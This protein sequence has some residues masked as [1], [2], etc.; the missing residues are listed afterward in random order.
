MTTNTP[1][2]ALAKA[3]APGDAA[4][5]S[6]MSEDTPAIVV[7]D[8]DASIRKSLDNLFRSI[9]FQ[10]ELFT[11]PEEFLQS[12]R[13]DR[14]GCMDRQLDV[15]RRELLLHIEIAAPWKAHVE[16]HYGL[17]RHPDVGA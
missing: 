17:W 16:H 4:R 9:G 5:A 6:L 13:L 2:A 3:Q 1:S 11:S 8:D 12:N 10:V 15:R 7:S 14:P